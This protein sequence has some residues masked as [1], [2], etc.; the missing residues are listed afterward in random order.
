MRPLLLITG[1]GFFVVGLWLCAVS[2][3]LFA[4]GHIGDARWLGLAGASIGGAGLCAGRLWAALY[5]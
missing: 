5:R 3:V 1:I 4:V 2:L